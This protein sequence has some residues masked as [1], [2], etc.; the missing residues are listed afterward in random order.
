M[1]DLSNKKT[2]KGDL[3]MQ[4]DIP[5]S[6]EWSDDENETTAATAGSVNKVGREADYFEDDTKEPLI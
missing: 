6:Y 2:N 1:Q 3:E 5:F 4:D